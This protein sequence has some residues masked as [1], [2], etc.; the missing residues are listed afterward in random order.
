MPAIHQNQVP[1][2]MVAPKILMVPALLLMSG[3]HEPDSVAITPTSEPRP[4]MIE[5]AQNTAGWAIRRAWNWAWKPAAAHG[6]NF[7]N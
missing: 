3:V 6:V 4:P 1:Y 7:T 2:E 5:H